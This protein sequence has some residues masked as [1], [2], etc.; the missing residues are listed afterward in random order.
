MASHYLRHERP[1][2]TL[3]ATALVHEAYLK[4]AGQPDA[5]WQNRAHF[6][7][8]ASQLMRRILVDYARAQHRGKRGGKQQKVS[9]DEALLVSADRTDELLQ[10]SSKTV[11]R[12]WSMAKAWL[13]GSLKE[14]YADLS[15]ELE[16]GKGTV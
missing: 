4:L 5:K 14:H 11:M 3:Q 7:A 12:E 16:A 10:L 6:F 15:R 13:Y 2:H 9:L 8:V 1:G